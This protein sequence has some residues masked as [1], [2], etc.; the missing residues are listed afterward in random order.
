VEV[1]E[2]LPPHGVEHRFAPLGLV[3]IAVDGVVTVKDC[4][5]T[6]CE[7]ALV[8]DTGWADWEL[9]EAKDLTSMPID[10]GTPRQRKA[11]VTESHPAWSQALLPA[12]WI[13]ARPQLR[14]W[15][16]GTYTFQLRFDLGPRVQGAALSL[17]LLADNTARVLLNNKEI[18][19]HKGGTLGHEE[20]GFK[21]TPT[22]IEDPKEGKAHLQAGENTLT[23][24]VT[25]TPSPDPSE[26]GLVLTG[27]VEVDRGCC[28]C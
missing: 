18:G 11:D 16:A 8:L 5:R 22:L 28:C 27:R 1:P 12:R 10:I 20:E 26:M 15:P 19:T 25:N 21:G 9:V 4:R 23:I 14:T 2:A 3:T 13:S 7:R 17:R 24:E 6:F